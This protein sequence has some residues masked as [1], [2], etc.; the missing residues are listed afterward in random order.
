M[1]KL[2]LLSP[3]RVLP[4]EDGARLPLRG[5]Q[6][7][8]PGMSAGLTWSEVTS[9]HMHTRASAIEEEDTPCARKKDAALEEGAQ[10]QWPKE[11]LTLSLEPSDGLARHFTGPGKGSA[12]S[13]KDVQGTPVEKQ[14]LPGQ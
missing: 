9:H 5:S 14:E 10:Q 4:E 8:I 6:P 11:M 13:R 2:Q 3:G 7:P 1:G 12:M